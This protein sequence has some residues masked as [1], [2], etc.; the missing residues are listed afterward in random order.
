MRR[1][2]CHGAS[3]A[4]ASEY[5]AGNLPAPQSLDQG[6][7]IDA[8]RAQ[9]GEGR[10]AV[11]LGEALAVGVGEQA[12]MMVERRRQAEQRLEQAVDVGRGEQVAA[13]HHVGD[14][15]RG[16]VDGDGEMIAGRRVLAGEHD[17]AEQ[18]GLGRDLARRSS[19][20]VSGPASAAALAMS[21]RQACGRAPASA[22]RQAPAGAG[23]DRPVRA[24]CGADA[25]AA[26]SAAISARVQKQG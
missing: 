16:V 15:L 5:P 22:R 11:A 3:L 18:L 9:D 24:R 6:G 19:H 14:A 17:V 21:S 8:R 25:L 2:V 23:I 4:S 12:M 20:Q 7:R 13:A 26:I 10:R 1:K